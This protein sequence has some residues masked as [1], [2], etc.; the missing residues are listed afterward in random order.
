M[1]GLEESRSEALRLARWCLIAG[2]FI[3]MSFSS[4]RRLSSCLCS[5]YYSRKL[6]YRQN[7]ASSFRLSCKIISRLCKSISGTLWRRNLILTWPTKKISW[8][9]SSTDGGVRTNVRRATLWEVVST[10]TPEPNQRNKSQ[11]SMSIWA[12]GCGFSQMRSKEL[13][14]ICKNQRLK[15]ITKGG[16]SNS[17]KRSLTNVLTR[18]ICFSRTWLSRVPNYFWIKKLTNMDTSTCFLSL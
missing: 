5:N 1:G 7:R 14:I 3:R 11:K 2:L 10:I 12:V 17:E 16:N 8:R 15:G 18:A 6:V 13:L 4:I 9:L